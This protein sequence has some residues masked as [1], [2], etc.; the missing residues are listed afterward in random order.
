MII[1][2]VP[3]VDPVV[4]KPVIYVPKL[5]DVAYEKVLVVIDVADSTKNDCPVGVVAA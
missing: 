4:M 1:P 3:D 5:T 2:N